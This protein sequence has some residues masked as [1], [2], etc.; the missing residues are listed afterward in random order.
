NGSNVHV[1]DQGPTTGTG[2]PP[3]VLLHGA[4]I[5]LRDWTF[6]HARQL[7]NQQR[8]IAMDRPGFGYSDR[9]DGEGSAAAQA[10]QLRATAA[11]MGATRPIVVGH[12]WGAAVALAWALDAPDEI[13]GVVSVSGATM[14]WGFGADVLD[15]LGIGRL[16]VD[17]YMSSLARGA[18][19]GSIERFVARAFQPQT[20]PR[21]YLS[22]VG[23]PLSLRAGTLQANSEDLA[24]LHPALSEQSGRYE[25]LRVPV[26]ILHG[27]RDWL[28]SVA[29][30]VTAFAERVPD[31]RVRIASGVGH[32]AHHA[33]PDLLQEAID[34]ISIRGT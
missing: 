21:G 9:R 27:D 30:H 10:A 22:Y 7:S 25:T 8:V 17:Y 14:P 2:R 5:N 16:G 29:Q 4:S 11:A 28:L 18:G 12:S 23:A 34:R 24:G 32:M 33:R 1:T 15:G 20:P 13:S 6:S 26:E 3:V 31:A 19:E